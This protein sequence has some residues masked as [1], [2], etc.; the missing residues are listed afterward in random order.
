MKIW[1]FRD[2]HDARFARAS[3]RGTWTQSTGTCPECGATSQRRVQPLVIEWEPD[4]DVVGDFVWPGFGSDI[5]VTDR[6]IEVLAAR[7]SK[8]ELGPV[9]MYQDPKLKRTKRS[10]PRVWLPYKGSPLYDLWVTYQVSVDHERSSISLQNRCSACGI[11]RYKVSGIERWE[12]NWDQ[13]RMELIP[14]HIERSQDQGLYVRRSDLNGYQLFRVN[15]APAWILCTD[16]V[17]EAIEAE[18]LTN[19]MFLEVGEIC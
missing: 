12:S 7:N 14:T 10:K 11:D 19:V 6:V 4:S 15:E 2:P 5:A 1:R 17:K 16:G 8:F 18:D 3:L 13:E 9:E